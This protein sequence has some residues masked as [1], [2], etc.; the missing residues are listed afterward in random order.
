M[1]F[2]KRLSIVVLLFLASRVCAQTGVLDAPVTLHLQ[3][4]RLEFIFQRISQDHP[5]TFSYDNRILPD[6]LQNA[7]FDAVPLRV[8]LDQLLDPFSLDWSLKGN[9]VIV[10]GSKPQKED[11]QFYVISGY[12]EDAVTGERLAGAQVVDL[13]SRNGT[14]SNDAGFFSLRLQADSVKLIISMLGYAVHAERMQ[15]RQDTRRLVKMAS[16]LS[17]ETVV[18]TDDEQ[19]LGMEDAGAS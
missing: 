9:I 2:V 19:T 5:L 6:A 18:I 7:D 11:A 13:R 8:V 16:D 15:L 10:T 17:L 4:Q 14:L 12:V 3:N 1:H